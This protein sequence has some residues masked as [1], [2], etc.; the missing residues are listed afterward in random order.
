[1]K[2]LFFI[3]FLF[4]TV[5]FAQMNMRTVA[6]KI[7]ALET[8]VALKANLTSPT[9][10]TPTL[11]VATAT[12]INKVKLTAPADSARIT[13]ANAKT[14][15]VSNTLTFTG[16]D[17]STLAIGTGGTLGTGAY[18]TIA[19]YLTTATASSTYAPLASPTFTGTVTVPKITFAGATTLD[20]A[21]V[22]S[23]TLFFYIGGSQYFS[24][25]K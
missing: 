9:L 22:A 18:A 20:S 21:K 12:S 24:V 10:V 17:G 8:A 15:T 2:R 3:L 19:N 14:L 11:G 6:A 13:I 23:D 1:M 5:S 25:K 16:T 4:A 7:A